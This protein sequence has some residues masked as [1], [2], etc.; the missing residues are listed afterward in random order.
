LLKAAARYL[1]PALQRTA[2]VWSVLV[3]V[4]LQVPN[5]VWAAPFAAPEQV[6]PSS[7]S[8]GTLRVVVALL[9]V[10]GAVVAAGRFARRMRGFSG[11]T[12][13]RLEVIGQLPVGPRE[14]AVLIRVG[15]HQLLLGVAPG[16][17]RTLHVFEDLPV[18]REPASDPATPERPTFKSVLLKS[19]GK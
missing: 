4:A 11:G 1:K 18:T 13:S 15:E 16:N 2:C 17:V 8:G 14:R 6:A 5:C 3:C 12:T 10:L 7:S 9:V 19:L